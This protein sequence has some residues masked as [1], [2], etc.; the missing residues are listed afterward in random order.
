MG[1]I[2]H[3]S[4]MES[5]Q[6]SGAKPEISLQTNFLVW[7]FHTGKKLLQL[8]ELR[9]TGDSALCVACAVALLELAV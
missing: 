9:R 6:S 2:F 3:K 7:K 1:L 5:L 4:E 8:Q